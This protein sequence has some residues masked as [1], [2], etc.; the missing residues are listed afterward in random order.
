MTSNRSFHFLLLQ[1][2]KNE[3]SLKVHKGGKDAFA[4]GQWHRIFKNTFS[5]S[6]TIYFAPNQQKRTESRSCYLMW[7]EIAYSV[8]SVYCYLTSWFTGA[9]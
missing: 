2:S 5:L 3:I 4:V 1:G 7:G 8:I 6:C 9:L